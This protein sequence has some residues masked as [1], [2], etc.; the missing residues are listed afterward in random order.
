MI[1]GLV[2]VAKAVVVLVATALAVLVVAVVV[3]FVALVTVSLRRQWQERELQR[4]LDLPCPP[5]VPE[6]RGR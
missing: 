1:A 5:D 4:L 2:L 6:D 3:A